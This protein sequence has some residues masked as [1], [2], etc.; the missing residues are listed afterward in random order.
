[1]TTGVRRRFGVAIAF[2]IATIVVLVSAP[3]LASSAFA[4]DPT[5]TFTMVTAPRIY[6]ST[7]TAGVQ[8][9]ISPGTWSPQPTGIQYQ[10]MLN[11]EP[12]DGETGPSFTPTTDEIGDTISFSETVSADGYTPYTFTGSNYYIYGK[13][14]MAPPTIVGV[15]QVGVPLTAV[16]GVITPAPDS[17]TYRWE[18][19]GTLV[20]SGTD[21]TTYTPTVSQVG[22]EIELD[23]IAYKQYYS[24]VGAFIY[25]ANILPA[26][27]APGVP[28]IVGSQVVGSTLSILANIF[29]APEETDYQWQ[30]DGTTIDGA[31]APTYTTVPDDVG[32][33]ISVA[34]T[35][36]HSNLPTLTVDASMSTAITTPFTT[37]PQP[38][39]MGN[40]AIG[41][42][43]VAHPGTWAPANA[44]FTYDWEVG[45]VWTGPETVS[46]VPL[47]NGY[48]VGKSIAVRVTAT[49]PGYGP[50][51][52]EASLST[53]PVTP[54][55][56]S[57]TNVTLGPTQVNGLF[58]PTYKLVSAL[59][60]VPLVYTWYRDG[61][62]I[63]GATSSEYTPLMVDEHQPITVKISITDSAFVPTSATSNAEKPTEGYLSDSGNLID[64]TVKVGSL[65]TA[66]TSGWV[67]IPSHVY[68][69]WMMAGDGPGTGAKVLSESAQYTP[70]RDV[71]GKYIQ[72][73][74]SA[75]APGYFTD[76]GWYGTDPILVALGTFT[77][78]SAPAISGLPEVG[79]PLTASHQLESPAAGV[80]YHYQ[81]YSATTVGGQL[82]AIARA[83]SSIYV[84]TTALAGQFLAVRVMATATGFASITLDSVS[85]GRVLSAPSL[86][87]AHSPTAPHGSG[88]SPS[89]PWPMRWGIPSRASL[90]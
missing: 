41:S 58:D 9:T 90:S 64:G 86:R 38:T 57:L 54:L 20:E 87:V 56:V 15:A 12:L 85:A 75:T 5:G 45:G 40:A 10:W 62:V 39:I 31:Q 82:T 73:W 80:T 4:D 33:I 79:S 7:P 19:S 44:T 84:P 66:N 2:A 3:G 71:G 34:I 51:T 21:A 63:P 67:G 8:V 1:V 69:R 53:A 30:R 74:E 78:T 52:S 46:A 65:L 59:P 26:A 47:T 83:T 22:Q 35:L 14:T 43:L 25:G 76:T 68:F 88:L 28:K 89:K 17:I 77:T 18:V 61:V 36:L 29:P 11:N 72:L 42:T 81:W 49:A 48:Y 6:T 55:A 16:P 70:T 24:N 50:T 60:D 13:L 37:V 27:F 32:H 23:V